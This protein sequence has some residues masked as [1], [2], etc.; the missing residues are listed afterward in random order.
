MNLLKTLPGVSQVAAQPWGT[1]NLTTARDLMEVGLAVSLRRS[2]ALSVLEYSDGR[3]RWAQFGLRVV[4]GLSAWMR[5][6]KP[7]SSQ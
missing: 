4:Y 6:Q 2:A 3:W 1:E 7:R 5:W